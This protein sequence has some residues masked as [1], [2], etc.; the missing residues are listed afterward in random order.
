MEWCRGE[1]LFFNTTLRNQ[2][3]YHVIAIILLQ[4]LLR[5]GGRGNDE[6]AVLQW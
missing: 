2:V 6:A 5:K 3:K 4:L 1:C